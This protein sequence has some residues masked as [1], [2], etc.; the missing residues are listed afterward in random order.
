MEVKN[1]GRKKP[2]W[3][4]KNI[5]FNNNEI[6][7][8]NII[9]KSN[10]NTVCQESKCPNIGECFSNSQATFLLL[11]NVCT[12]NCKFCNISNNQQELK[13]DKNEPANVASAVKNMG[14]KYVVLTSVTRDDLEDGGASVFARTIE[15]INKIDKNI[16]IEV[17]VPDFKGNE[18]SILEI[19]G[20]DINVFGHNLETVP[21]IYKAIRENA[22]YKR[23]LDVL[24]FA[25]KKSKSI[26]IKS[27]IMVGLGEKY[28]EVLALMK[29][30]Y[31]IG[32][33]ILTIGQYL[34][35]TLK[36]FPVYEYINPEIFQNYREFGENIGIKKVIAGPF[37]RSSY[38]AE[39]FFY[40]K[41]I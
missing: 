21:R 31:D 41:L 5:N 33:E 14:L 4:K 36:S 1:A 17:L 28:E 23:S 35:P 27:G 12:R 37:V 6:K 9:N 2:H 40:K 15:E 8:K 39:N 25:A 11:G 26:I 29:D 20:K 13:L 38:L 24:E 34:A 22:S 7:V 16:K 19:L 3:L 10:L 30:F 18:K 32:G